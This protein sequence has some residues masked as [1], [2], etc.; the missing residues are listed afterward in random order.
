LDKNNKWEWKRKKIISDTIHR[1]SVLGLT[2]NCLRLAMSLPT[3]L[4]LFISEHFLYCRSC[5]YLFFRSRSSRVIRINLFVSTAHHADP[6]LMPRLHPGACLCRP[7]E[8][9]V[10]VT[11]SYV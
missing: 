5:L 11:N 6:I 3:A 7:M 10:H 1:A 8:I 4:P 9:T 2:T